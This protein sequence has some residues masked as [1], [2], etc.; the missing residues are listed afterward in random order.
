V[1]ID[2]DL[3]ETEYDMLEFEIIDPDG[4]RIGIGS[5]LIG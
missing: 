2:A 1:A 5:E 4:Y 3:S